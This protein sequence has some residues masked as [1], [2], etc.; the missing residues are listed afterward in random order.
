M[1]AKISA[2]AH[3]ALRGIREFFAVH[4]ADIDAV[5][6]SSQYTIFMLLSYAVIIICTLFAID[7]VG[8]V[9]IWNYPLINLLVVG[10]VWGALLAAYFSIFFFAD[11]MVRVRRFVA[12][13]SDVLLP[14]MGDDINGTHNSG[15]MR[16]MAGVKIQD[17]RDIYM[18]LWYM[19]ITYIIA[20]VYLGVWYGK[21]HALG[22]ISELSNNYAYVDWNFFQHMMGGPFLLLSI[23]TTYWAAGAYH[24]AFHESMWSGSRL[25]AYWLN[26]SRSKND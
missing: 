22:N 21:N 4:F 23:L 18:H 15:V 10:I 17:R 2:E 26:P 3:V 13:G 8:M 24:R 20:V 19:I 12:A 9:H 16:Y 11:T 5:Y 25:L 6:Q 7:S 14:G 1:S